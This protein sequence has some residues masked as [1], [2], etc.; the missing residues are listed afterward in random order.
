MRD[1]MTLIVGLK[2]QAN[3]LLLPTGPLDKVI[4]TCNRYIVSQANISTLKLFAELDEAFI[5]L[6]TKVTIGVEL[7]KEIHKKA[8]K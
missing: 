2:K 1:L 7:L 4:G 6:Q 8:V 5:E 3:S